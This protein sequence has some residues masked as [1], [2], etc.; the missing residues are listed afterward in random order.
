MKNQEAHKYLRSNKQGINLNKIE[1][2]KRNYGHVNVCILLFFLF[3]SAI[4][5]EATETVLFWFFHTL[6]NF[7][8]PLYI[9]FDFP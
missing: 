9:G 3:I 1:E 7:H 2:I 6:F 8:N 4:F 5:K